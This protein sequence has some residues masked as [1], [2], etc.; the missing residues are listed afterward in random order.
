MTTLRPAGVLCCY[1]LCATG[2]AAASAPEPGGTWHFAV[3]L[4][5]K[6]IG[7]HDFIVTRHADE[8][9]VVTAAH[10]RVKAAFL[11]L[12]QYDH[13][14]HE[15]WHGGCLTRITSQTHDNGKPF[16]V[17]GELQGDTFRVQ[18]SRGAAT[19]PGCVK[20]FAYWDQRYLTE[21]RLLN[22]QTGEFQ[23]VTLTPDGPE[24]LKVRGRVIPARRYSLRGPKLD[25]ELWYAQS[26]DWVALESK[27]ASGRTL[28]YE[29]Q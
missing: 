18:G 16:A 3:L 4:D 9:E 1:I 2:H 11:S 13:Q 17:Q 27:L 5:G 28:R 24:N 10:F 23:S 8:T 15:V 19:L 22:S 21:P 14:D 26:G 20:T 12:Y 7:V 29:I 25:V 6:R